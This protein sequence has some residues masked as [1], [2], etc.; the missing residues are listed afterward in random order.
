M[1]GGGG[2]KL[3]VGGHRGNLIFS[4]RKIFP[5]YENTTIPCMRWDYFDG[6]FT[7]KSIPEILHIQEYF[8]K[9]YT[10]YEHLYKISENPILNPQPNA[11]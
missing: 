2:R 3:V 4:Y 10:K 11:L 7:P 1:E 8:S 9:T 5:Y 6:N